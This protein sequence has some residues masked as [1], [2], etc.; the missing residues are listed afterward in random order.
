MRSPYSDDGISSAE[1]MHWELQYYVTG[2]SKKWE[3]ARIPFVRKN[4]ASWHIGWWGSEYAA[5]IISRDAA[6]AEVT[7]RIL[8]EEVS[9]LLDAIQAERKRR[10]L[11]R[12]LTRDFVEVSFEEELLC[13]CGITSKDK[14]EYANLCKNQDRYSEKTFWE[15]KGVEEFFFM[16]VCPALYIPEEGIFWSEERVNLKKK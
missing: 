4:L 16:G 1:V 9:S 14:Y 7:K 13:G 11:N 5:P 8:R 2:T 6:I 3:S 10:L 12:D 15:K